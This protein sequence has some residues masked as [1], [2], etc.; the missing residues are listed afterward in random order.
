MTKVHL[1]L[2]PKDN[3]LIMIII[4]KKNVEKDL[5]YHFINKVFRGYYRHND[6]IKVIWIGYICVLELCVNLSFKRKRIECID[7]DKRD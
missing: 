5:N 4:H 3:M 1:S 2:Q 6:F 7:K